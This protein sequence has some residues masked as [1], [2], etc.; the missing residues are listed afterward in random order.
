VKVSELTNRDAEFERSTP[1]IGLQ[2]LDNRDLIVARNSRR[3][4]SS[5]IARRVR[6]ANILAV[7]ARNVDRDVVSVTFLC[8][9]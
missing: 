3:D 7:G 5:V 8:G 9:A 2:A 4:L 6:I 1:G